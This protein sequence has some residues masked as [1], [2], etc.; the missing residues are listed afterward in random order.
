MK[1]D[2]F[3][4]KIRFS[5]MLLFASML[6]VSACNE[7]T[8]PQN[9]SDVPTAEEQ[10]VNV[11]SDEESIPETGSQNDDC[12]KL[13]TLNMLMEKYR[14]ATDAMANNGDGLDYNRVS[15]ISSTIKMNINDF[16]RAGINAFTPECWDE[17]QRIK[18][19]FES[20]SISNQLHDNEPMDL[21][22]DNVTD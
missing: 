6:L 20:I 2:D 10:S 9:D 13:K 22:M 19:E 15:G 5:L 12:R 3:K 1:M 17:Y 21:D 8:T 4:I 16:D 7:S 11:G 18:G 14:A